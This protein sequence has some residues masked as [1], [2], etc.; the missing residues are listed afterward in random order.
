MPRYLPILLPFTWLLAGMAAVYGVRAR[1]VWPEIGA[2]WLVVALNA[3]LAA[4]APRL[5]RDPDLTKRAFKTLAAQVVRAFL[6]GATIFLAFRLDFFDFAAFLAASLAG[7]LMWLAGHVLTLHH[8]SLRG[9]DSNG[10]RKP[11][12]SR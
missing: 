2:G 10:L 1:L 5:I 12:N 4:L 7:Y 6:L 9:N 3:L 11:S 8:H